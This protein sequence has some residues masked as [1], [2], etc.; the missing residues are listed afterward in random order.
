MRGELEPAWQN[1]ASASAGAERIQ[2]F[3]L[4][5]QLLV[6]RAQGNRSRIDETLNQY[7]YPNAQSLGSEFSRGLVYLQFDEQDK[8]KNLIRDFEASLQTAQ[9]ERPN[10]ASTLLGLIQLYGLQKD[11]A[12]LTEAIKA[13]YAVVKPDALRAV[14]NRSIPLAYATADDSEALMDFLDD[15]VDQFGPWEFYYFIT[16]PSFDNLR[17]L[18]RFQALDKRYRQWLEQVE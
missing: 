4:D 10:A 5:F 11:R 2:S 18:P 3:Y 7:L 16:D 6:A 13:Y 8:L 15:M 1:I 14:E 9:H 12:K 17:D